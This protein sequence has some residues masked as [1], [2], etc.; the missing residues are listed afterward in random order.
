[1]ENTTAENI[2][3]SVGDGVVNESSDKPITDT[4]RK[5]TESP[6]VLPCEQIEKSSFNLA[7]TSI[8]ATQIMQKTLVW[9]QPEQ[10]VQQALEQIKQQNI[11][12]IIVGKDGISQGILSNSDLK[13]AVSPYLRP[14]FA[15][16]RTPH[17]D[18]TLKIKIK[19]VMSKPVQS[20]APDTT[21]Y[22]IMEKMQQ[23]GLKCFSVLDCAGKTQGL[24]T[25]SEVFNSLLNDK[26]TFSGTQK[27]L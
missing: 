18:A 27:D 8:T 26:R 10:S 22:E 25:V 11:S 14:I 4:I 2:A 16:W 13:G 7:A 15:K 19:W 24:V 21:L 3:A 12:Y 6:A 17:D 5:M 1:M 9:A 23:T 20:V